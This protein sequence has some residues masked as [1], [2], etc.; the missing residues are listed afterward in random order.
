MPVSPAARWARGGG[1][2]S[3]VITSRRWLTGERPRADEKRRDDAR[4]TER[5]GRPRTRTEEGDS[6]G[7]RRRRRRREREDDELEDDETHDARRAGVGLGARGEWRRRRGRV[8]LTSFS[9]ASEDDTFRSERRTLLTR[10]PRDLP[11]RRSHHFSS[12]RRVSASRAEM[13]AS[14]VLMEVVAPSLG[15]TLA[16]VLFLSAVPELS[17]P[18]R[19]RP[20]RQ[21]LDGSVNYSPRLA[22]VKGDSRMSTT[23]SSCRLRPCPHRRRNLRYIPDA[24]SIGPGGGV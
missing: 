4:G 22:S 5:R 24:F 23:P 17:R 1:R 12:P 7:A 16:N 11:P 20:I 8:P 18:R 2:G 9:E 21:L 15:F 13:S 19:S 6:H 14:Y 3:D 10:F